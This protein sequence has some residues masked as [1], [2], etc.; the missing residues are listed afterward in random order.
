MKR[1]LVLPIPAFI[2][3]FLVFVSGAGYTIG[4]PRIQVG[5]AIVTS[6]G[7]LLLLAT[8]SAVVEWSRTASPPSAPARYYGV[9]LMGL[10][11]ILAGQFVG[12]PVGCNL[13]NQ[14]PGD[15]V[16][17]WSTIWPNALS[18]FAGIVLTAWGFG[19]A[20]S[21]GSQLL[22]LGLGV[23]IGGFLLL[24]SGLSIGYITH[25][26]A[27]GC[28]PLTT[29]QWWSLFWPDVIA[30]GLGSV[31]IVVGLTLA[32]LGRRRNQ[33]GRLLSNGFSIP[34]KIAGSNPA[35]PT[36]PGRGQPTE[37]C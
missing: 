34:T 9:V 19:K 35:D 17:T 28:P 27:N 29:G 24:T 16:G 30:E 31:C 25:C 32:F 3:A 10:F 2:G 36:K 26:P 15:P 13:A 6:A 37:F 14:C 7:I 23:A 20:R 21:G 22:P 11:L 1:L 5:L 33:L 4:F 12:F 18:T 8:T